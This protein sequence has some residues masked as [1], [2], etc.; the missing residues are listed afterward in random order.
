LLA[1]STQFLQRPDHS[2]AFG[3]PRGKIPLL[4]YRRMIK[5]R[6]AKITLRLQKLAGV[7]TACMENLSETIQPK[8]INAIQKHVTE[9]T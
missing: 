7:E 2:F 9:N 1:T 4:K 3:A 5:K 6:G 8:C